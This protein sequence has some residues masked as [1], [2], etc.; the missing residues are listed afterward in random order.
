MQVPICFNSKENVIP[1]SHASKEREDLQIRL[2][3][4]L[5]HN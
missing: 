2:L 5:L 1:K 4:A 3:I